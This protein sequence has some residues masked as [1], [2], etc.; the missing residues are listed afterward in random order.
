MTY[1]IT[2][3]ASRAEVALQVVQTAA[4]DRTGKAATASTA[5]FRSPDP[6]TG[7]SF[8]TGAADAILSLVHAQAQSRAQL[9]LSQSSVHGEAGAQASGGGSASAEAHAWSSGSGAEDGKGS[10][11]SGQAVPPTDSA[12]STSTRGTNSHGQTAVFG[13]TKGQT[14]G[15][16]PRN[17]HDDNEWNWEWHYNDPNASKLFGAYFKR[18]FEIAGILGAYNDAWRAEWE[19]PPE[20]YAWSWAWV[21]IPRKSASR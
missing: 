20:F 10:A 6:R 3:A 18:E 7:R 14:D 11:A 8:A 1:A 21:P 5:A 16:S 9:T 15:I 17:P 12:G 13:S 2:A 19:H 4:D